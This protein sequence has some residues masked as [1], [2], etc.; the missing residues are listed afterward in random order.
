MGCT[1]RLSSGPFGLPADAASVDWTVLNDTN[2]PQEVRVTVFAA[3]IGQPKRE[4]PPGPVEV[5]VAPWSATHN[6]NSV[7]PGQPFEHGMPTEVVV[8]CNDT[9][10]LPA[11]EVWCDHGATVVAGTRIGPRDFSSLN[12]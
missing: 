7:G 3:P 5:T 11:V 2:A 9:R 4:L 10:V 12:G 1:Y 8:R 6:A